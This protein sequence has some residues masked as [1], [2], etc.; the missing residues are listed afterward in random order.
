MSDSK[1]ALVER[2]VAAA[3][4]VRPILEKR[5]TAL[6]AVV[7]PSDAALASAR[8]WL[9]DG[10]PAP[11]AKAS[12]DA[13][14][15]IERAWLT[16]DEQ[17]AVTKDLVALKRA[18]HAAEASLLAARA[19]AWTPDEPGHVGDDDALE[20]RAQ[21]AIGPSWAASQAERCAELAQGL[22]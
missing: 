17:A 13:A 14:K 7:A 2:A 8:Q 16:W 21:D 12:A 3:A 4:S 9:I 6:T 11:A 5:A 18:L 19:A 20:A 10:D 15:V 1:R 22:A